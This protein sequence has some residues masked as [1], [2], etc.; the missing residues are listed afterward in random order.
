V[1]GQSLRLFVA[2]DVPRDDLQ[3]LQ[4]RIAPLRDELK[5]ARWTPVANQHVTLRFLGPTPAEQLESVTETL[6]ATARRHRPAEVSLSRTGAF[7]SWRRARVLWM[8]LDDPKKLLSGLASDLN[9]GYEALG[10]RSE[11]RGFTPHLT[12]A[13]FKVPVALRD[14]VRLQATD[15]PPFRVERITLWCSRLHPNGARYEVVHTQE[16]S[17][18][19]SSEG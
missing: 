1:S 11:R 13:R 10:Y 5:N 2:T 3:W 16:L 15:R 7:P 6:A 9:H 19:A 14:S 8:G 17:E 18:P 12:L 4:E